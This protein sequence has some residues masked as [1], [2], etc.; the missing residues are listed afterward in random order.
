[1]ILAIL[2]ARM[3]SSRLPGKVLMP[4]LGQPML[5]RQIERLS[6]SR[7]IEKL[8]VATSV[9]DDDAP[10]AELCAAIGVGCFRGALADVL[11]RFYQAARQHG[12]PTVVRLTGDCPLIDPGVTDAV[13]A[14]QANGGYDYC[15]NVLERSF[16]IGLDTEIMTFAALETAW[17]QARLPSEREHVTPYIHGNPE[18]FRLGGLKQDDNYSHWRWTVDYPDDFAFVSGV[19]EALYPANP[20]FAMADIV[21]LLRERPDIAAL[22]APDRGNDGQRR[23]AAD[24]EFRAARSKGRN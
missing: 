5:A 22:M 16:P 20:G 13:I 7:R 9:N 10:I 24:A 19:Y 4:I 17:R 1:M 18:K 23:A 21:A 8:I 12:Q 14:L 15:S 2:Q 6:R 3:S 11:D